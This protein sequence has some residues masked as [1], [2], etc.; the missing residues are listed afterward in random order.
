MYLYVSLLPAV[1]QRAVKVVHKSTRKTTIACG[2]CF[3][4]NRVARRE[5]ERNL[6]KKK[7]NGE[8]RRKKGNIIERKRKEQCQRE[9]AV[10]NISFQ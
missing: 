5:L 7:E 1:C 4:I 2:M 6:D 8:E 3:T 9:R 10:E